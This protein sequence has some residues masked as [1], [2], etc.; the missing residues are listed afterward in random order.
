MQI[1]VVGLERVAIDSFRRDGILLIGVTSVDLSYTSNDRDQTPSPQACNPLARALPNLKELDL[2]YMMT[3]ATIFFLA[4]SPT[5]SSHLERF[6]LS[7]IV[8]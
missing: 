6:H 3:Q 5:S 2:S 7:F 4:L 8:G 1:R